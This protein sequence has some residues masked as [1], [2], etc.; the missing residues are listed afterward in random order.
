MNLEKLK[1][2][3]NVYLIYSPII[4]YAS[5]CSIQ[6]KMW[7]PSKQG[8]IVLNGKYSII[9]AFALF[10]VYLGYVSFLISR[11]DKKEINSITIISL[12]CATFLFLCTMWMQS[13]DDF[14]NS[15]PELKP[16]YFPIIQQKIIPVQNIDSLLFF[17]KI[18]KEYSHQ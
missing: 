7:V 6:K 2:N 17:Q 18:Q 3:L 4:I 13:Q 14:L 10:L 5:V 11:R 16:H 8:I 12:V 15:H 9:G 1:T